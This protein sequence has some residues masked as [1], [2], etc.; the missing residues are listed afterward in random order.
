MG[1]TCLTLSMFIFCGEVLTGEVLLAKLV[2]LVLGD[3]KFQKTHGK[4][5][6]SSLTC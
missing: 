6:G 3:E 5:K 2:I 1:A 4:G